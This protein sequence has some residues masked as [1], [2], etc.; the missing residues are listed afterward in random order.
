MEKVMVTCSRDNLASERTILG[1]GG[2][3]EKEVQVDGAADEPFPAGYSPE[4]TCCRH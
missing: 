3:F 1:C 2:V 4:S